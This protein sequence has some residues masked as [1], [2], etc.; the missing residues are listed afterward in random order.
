ME[1]FGALELLIEVSFSWN[2][3]VRSSLPSACVV[4]GE[5]DFGGKDK[6]LEYVTIRHGDISVEHFYREKMYNIF[7]LFDRVA[8]IV[9]LGRPEA[10]RLVLQ[11]FQGTDP[12][13]CFRTLF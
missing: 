10:E 12:E 2:A 3:F 6:H 9:I 1:R 11:H 5:Y 8:P 4:Q 13:L 7:T